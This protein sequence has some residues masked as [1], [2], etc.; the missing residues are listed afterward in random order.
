MAQTTQQSAGFTL[1]PAQLGRS[2]LAMVQTSSRRVRLLTAVL[3][4]VF[5]TAH[6]LGFWIETFDELL[7]GG[8][9]S[10]VLLAAEIVLTAV[11]FAAVLLPLLHWASGYSGLE[12]RQPRGIWAWPTP[13]RL[14]AVFSAMALVWFCYWLLLWPG[15]TS[16]D[17]YQQLKQALGLEPYSDHH[18]LVHTLGIQTVL[19]P[20]LEVTGS[21][22]AAISVVSLVQLLLLAGLFT[23]FFEM[24]RGLR[25]PSWV[26]NLTL[27]LFAL[28][29]LTGW[30][31][32]TLWKDM[33]LA[34]FVLLL[35]GVGVVIV[36][37]GADR[38]SW[39]WW[40]L[41]F[42][43][44]LGALV[45]KKTGVYVVVP[46]ILGTSILLRGRTL[47][48]WLGLG[49]IAVG[50][51]FA[52]HTTL[53]DSLDATAGS[54]V[55][56]FSV[57]SQQIARVVRDAPESLTTQDW[58][59]LA[60]FYPGG[61]LGLDYLPHLADN[62]KGAMDAAAFEADPRGY[63][64]F[65][66]RLGK[67]NPVLYV[68]ATLAGTSGY[69]YPHT[70]YWQTQATDWT[71]LVNTPQY[72]HGV[73]PGSVDPEITDPRLEPPW[74]KGAAAT[75]VNV[76]L[77]SIPVLGAAF[78]IGG[79]TW[80]ALVFAAVAFLRRRRAHV[81]A[82]LLAA[83]VL[84]TCLISPVFAEARYAYPILLLLPLLGITAFER[85][86]P[87]VREPHGLPAGS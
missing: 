45:A 82:F 17:S 4:V 21:I 71:V 5:A 85:R 53:L 13:R 67:A 11:V 72:N 20:A 15:A 3:C 44:A 22:S 46:F 59:D 79:W 41:F 63:L 74:H 77:P 7:R 26:L 39:R 55:E 28:H 9:V 69:W 16:P 87:Q 14:F 2:W 86:E 52:I 75:M 65:W 60:R 70:R 61:D 37:R 48:T 56:A 64:E 12:A 47:V 78:S 66:T 25:L 43:A 76:H 68:E 24:L 57:P 83:A 33:W 27:G 73:T 8:P 30:F 62:T 23:L 38:I 31:S 40:T 29:P 36:R 1:S 54:K 58:A 50:S 19:R 6:R 18:P 49:L 10:L 42:G 51:Y 35:A 32:V 81:P 34:T 80:A 84:G